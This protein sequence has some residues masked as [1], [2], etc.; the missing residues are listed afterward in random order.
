MERTRKIVLISLLVSLGLILHFVEAMLPMAF[1]VPGAKLGLANIVSL[2]GIVLFG[3]QGGFLILMMR[4]IL[5]SLMAG[6]LMT[7]NFYLSIA[8]GLLSFL[9]MYGAYYYLGKR[10]SLLGISILGAV[11]HNLGQIV[12]A[13]YIIANPGIFYYLPYL[14]LLAV[15]TGLGVGLVTYYTLSYLNRYFVKGVEHV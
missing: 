4:I 8:G 13:Y 2:M 12:T 3:F 5:A 9:F 7:I 6:T 10:F 15:P 1:I 11:F 14:I